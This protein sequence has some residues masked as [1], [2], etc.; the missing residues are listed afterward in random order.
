MDKRMIQENLQNQMR[1]KQILKNNKIVNLLNKFQIKMTNI[2][3]IN[4]FRFKMMSLLSKINNKNKKNNKKNK[5]K[6][7]DNMKKHMEDKTINLKTTIL[8]MSKK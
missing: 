7:E 5:L 2:N 8:L 1:I 3:K 6:I 4:R